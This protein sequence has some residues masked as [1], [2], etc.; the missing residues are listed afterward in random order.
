MATIY[1]AAR[2]VRLLFKGGI[3]FFGKPGDINY[4]CMDKVGTSEIVMV[5]RHCQ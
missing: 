3:Y 1:F 5:A 2:F 4:G